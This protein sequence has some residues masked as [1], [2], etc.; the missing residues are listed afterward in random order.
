VVE[1]GLGRRTCEKLQRMWPLKRT[2]EEEVERKSEEEMEA[3]GRGRGGEARSRVAA[4]R[5]VW[6][7]EHS[8]Q[9]LSGGEE[10]P[11]VY[12]DS[13][14]DFHAGTGQEDLQVVT[15]RIQAEAAI[16]AATATMGSRVVG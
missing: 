16:R 4:R 2:G 12:T 8:C 10:Q 14:L 1:S 6:G 13:S 15:I 5:C 11:R 7:K 9:C 3:R